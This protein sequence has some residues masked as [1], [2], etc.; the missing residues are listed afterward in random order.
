[1]KRRVLR[2]RYGR[3]SAQ[4]TFIDIGHGYRVTD[5]YASQLARA[6]GRALSTL[7]PGYALSITLPGGI[8]AWLGRTPVSTNVYG[9][10]PPPRGWV[11]YVYPNDSTGRAFFDYVKGVS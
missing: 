1:M 10:T 5:G 11:W 4:K 8:K 2:R 6:E 9:F 3:A 7:K